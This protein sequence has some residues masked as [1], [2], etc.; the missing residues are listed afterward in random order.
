MPRSSTTFA[1][2]PDQVMRDLLAEFERFE[3]ARQLQKPRK[4]VDL[5]GQLIQ[6]RYHKRLTQKELAERS[7]VA[8]AV[9]ARIESGKGNPTMETLE[10]IVKV[11]GRRVGLV[12]I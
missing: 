1:P 9:I 6:A 3:K 10:R 2:D 8:Q 12:E 11:L 4:H 7:G 5:A